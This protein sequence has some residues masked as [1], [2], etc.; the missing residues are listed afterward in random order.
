VSRALDALIASDSEGLAPVDL[1]ELQRK[2]AGE[3]Y[4]LAEIVARLK[5]DF[6]QKEVDR[7]S[8]YLRAKLT[9]KAEHLGERAMSETAAGDIAEGRPEVIRARSEEIIAEAN[10]EAMKL[11]LNAS[12]DVL[13]SL[14]MRLSN[15][16]D[17]R[18]QT[19]LTQHQ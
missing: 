7:K 1:L 4:H 11:K 16:R 17:E 18:K 13:T 9:A 8:I 2:I 12:G 5:K 15:L 14:T 10:Y 6:L 3:R 19:A